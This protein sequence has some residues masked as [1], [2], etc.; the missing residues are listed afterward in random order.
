MATVAL[1]AARE[2]AALSSIDESLEKLALSGVELPARPRKV[3]NDHFMNRVLNFEHMAEVL[4]LVANLVAV[5]GTGF[6]FE[7][8]TD[9]DEVEVVMTNPEFTLTEDNEV[10]IEADAVETVQPESS[11][12]KA[13]DILLNGVIT[14]NSITA[15]AITTSHIAP[16]LTPEPEAS[17]TTTQ[18]KRRR[19]N[20]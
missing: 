19:S 10:R 12:I 16:G 5:T 17:T 15:D 2:H 11:V 4:D 14:A 1:L 20:R 7:D 9:A 18:T 6:G 13:E 8:D 3:R